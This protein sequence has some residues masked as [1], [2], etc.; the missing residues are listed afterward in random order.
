MT[1]FVRNPIWSN[2]VIIIILVFGLFSSGFNISLPKIVD[3]DFAEKERYGLEEPVA[4]LFGKEV[5]MVPS[6]Q[7]PG[8]KKSFFPELTSR[9]IQVQV[10]YPGASP[11]EMEEGVTLK[12]EDALAGEEGIE[13]IT[14]ISTENLAIITIEVKKDYDVDSKLTDVKNAVDKINSFPVDAEKPVIFIQDIPGDAIS[15]ILKG[16]VDLQE[17][18]RTAENTEDDFL[19]TGFISQIALT[20]YPELEISIDVNE[21]TLKRFNLTFDDISN[22]VSRNNQDISGGTIRSESE[23]VIIRSNAKRYAPE[24]IA[25]I[26]LRTNT[27]GSVIR[28]KDVAK[29]EERFS[30][31]PNKTMYDGENAVGINVQKLPEED[32]VQITDYVK[33][34]VRTFNARNSS[35]EIIVQKDQS[36]FL[37]Q[38]LNLLIENGSIGLLMVL[39]TLGLF[40]SVRLSFWV[41]F[42][43]PLSFFGMFFVASLM[44]VTI[45]MISLFGMILVIGIL[46]DDGIVVAENVF[47]HYERGKSRFQAAVDGT[48][49]VIAPVVASVMTTILAFSLIFFLDGRLGEFVREMAIVVIACLAFSLVDALIVL[50]SHLAYSKGLSR[51]KP[52]RIRAFIEK[53]QNF[54]RDNIFGPFLKLCINNWPI[55]IAVTFLFVLTTVGMISGGVITQVIF[56]DID[57]DE[58]SVSLVLPPG[59]R[60]NVTEDLLIDLENKIWSTNEKLSENS[61]KSVI[62]S[63]KRDIGSALGESGSHTGV[64]T[65]KILTGEQRGELKSSTVSQALREAIGLIPEADKLVVGT[66]QIFGKAV[67]VSLTSKNLDDLLAVRDSLKADLQNFTA[68]T[69]ITDN[70]VVGRREILIQL[71]NEAYLL[72][73]THNDIA[74]QIRQGFF[75][76]EIQRLQKGDDEVRVWTRY[77][78]E[79]R[80]SLGQ[81][82]DMKIRTIQGQEYPLSQL[83][84]YQIERGLVSI[85]HRDAAKEITIEADVKDPNEPVPDLLNKI[86]TE[87]L[88]GILANYPNVRFAF[89]GQ[90]QE[91]NK[92]AASIAT[93]GPIILIL[94]VLLIAL[95]FNSF[96][97]SYMIIHLVIL[98]YFCA[99]FGHFIEGKPMSILSTY[100]IIALAGVIVNDAVVFT[101]KFNTSLKEGMGFRD[102]LYHT[103]ISR[104]RPIILTSV[105]T[106]AGLYPLILEKSTQAQFL[107][108]MAI[109]VAYG[110]LIGTFL[111]LTYYPAFI[112]GVN[113]LRRFNW[114]V[115]KGEW[116]TPEEVEPT[117]RKLKELQAGENE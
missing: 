29:V 13:E 41:A 108:P 12:V 47:A 23:E 91:S 114:W 49:E 5:Y 110:V 20:G 48:V 16:D 96:T 11:E 56:P 33:D 70:Y 104:F 68:L 105:T 31:T 95:V 64:L 66:R 6:I 53:W 37:K 27:D 72:G 18:K 115:M 80:K 92:M 78:A 3:A 90:Q 15:L 98:G 14:S 82:E 81:L 51:E 60:E 83:V 101:D 17:L 54:L 103:G 74:R 73:L 106:V 61:D 52:G 50:P 86:E 2:V 102:A 112:I 28:I 85:S 21:T 7:L 109:S 44:G 113:Y 117:M 39:I 67:N 1:F 26:I 22:A 43:I 46:V 30:E 111:I 55:T 84:D 87:I 24:E 89:K 57:R 63:I 62:E 35:M 100:G 32:V 99:A 116:P 58:I 36:D 8:L 59:V 9:I 45:N 10:V 94:I 79:D 65:V 77:A 40:L 71:K 34:Y 69:N 88:P 25:N 19:S 38:R 107:V 76:Q 75:G 4:S 42:S 97:Q 93:A